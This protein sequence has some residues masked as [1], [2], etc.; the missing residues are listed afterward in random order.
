MYA[1]GHGAIAVYDADADSTL[2]QEHIL[3]LSCSDGRA[4]LD[5]N[6]TGTP[7]AGL[8]TVLDISS[9]CRSTGAPVFNPFP[10]FGQPNLWPRGMPSHSCIT[11][12][13]LCFRRTSAR[14]VIQ[15]AMIDGQPDVSPRPFATSTG[16]HGTVTLDS[17]AFSVVLPAGV[18][19]AVNR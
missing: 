11:T 1:I 6:V 13:S 7:C 2:L 12:N 16:S 18:L 3:G 5:V 15:Q 19:A 17:T 10:L 8:H 9:G 4:D 14:P